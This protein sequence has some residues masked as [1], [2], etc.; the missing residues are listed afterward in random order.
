MR[1]ISQVAV[2]RPPLFCDLDQSAPDEL[3]DCVGDTGLSHP[4]LPEVCVGADQIAVALP[5]VPGV[6]DLEP[7][8][9]LSLGKLERAKSGGFEHRD[10]MR[11]ELLANL[12]TRAEIFAAAALCWVGV[13][14]H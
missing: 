4:M 9:N 1:W 14:D 11:D 10:G 8:E 3:L 7:V 5:A 12:D 13:V 2:A 6:L